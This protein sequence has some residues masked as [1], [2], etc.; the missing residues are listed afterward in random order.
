MLNSMSY[1]LLMLS[2]MLWSCQA[3][4]AEQPADSYLSSCIAA[5]STTAGMANCTARAHALWESELNVKYVDLR[6]MLTP[7]QK[8]ALR[9]SQRQWIAY[10][11]REFETIDAFYAQLEGTMYIPMRA[12]DRLKVTKARVIQI[13]SYISLLK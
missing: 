6:N 2:A 12:A 10:R 5:D 11:D 9:D 8:R 13:N 1:M 4:A 7:Q 3:M